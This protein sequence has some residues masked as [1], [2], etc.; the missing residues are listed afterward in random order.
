MTAV[1]VP[2]G[3]VRRRIGHGPACRTGT[4][5]EQDLDRRQIPGGEPHEEEDVEAPAVAGAD[6]RHCS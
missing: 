6:E 3:T 4:A 2:A 5:A 1:T